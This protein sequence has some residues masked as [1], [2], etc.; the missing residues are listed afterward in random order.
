MFTGVARTDVNPNSTVTLESTVGGFFIAGTFGNN[1]A[2]CAYLV[3]ASWTGIHNVTTLCESK[4]ISCTFKNCRS[5]EN[6]IRA[7]I[8]AGALSGSVPFCIYALT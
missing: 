3:L 6:K 8:N 5:T 1:Y 4:N 2:G 7:T